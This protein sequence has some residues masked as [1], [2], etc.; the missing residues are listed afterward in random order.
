MSNGRIYHCATCGKESTEYMDE[1][2]SFGCYAGRYCS[3]QCWY[4]S[5]Y[6]DAVD[7]NATFDEMDAGESLEAEPDC[8]GEAW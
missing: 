8:C 4:R 6:R 7:P 3:D 2:H 5:G 1:Y